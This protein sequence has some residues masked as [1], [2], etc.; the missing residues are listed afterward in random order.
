MDTE[1]DP[2]ATAR[3]VQK[4]RIGHL[5]RTAPEAGYTTSVGYLM[6]SAREDIDNL[7][8]LRDRL[9]ETGASG[10][11]IRDKC[12]QYHD[13]TVAE[14][15]AV[16][17]ELVDFGLGLYQRKWELEAAIDAATTVEDVEAVAW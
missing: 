17:G 3:E 9:L 15:S 14:L 5:F 7:A 16:V 12:N 2:V 11:T 13:V 10:A 4:H 6:D 1:I 8:R